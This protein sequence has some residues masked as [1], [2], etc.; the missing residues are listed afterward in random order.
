LSEKGERPFHK[1]LTN[2]KKKKKKVP[3]KFLTNGPDLLSKKK[4]ESEKKRSEKKNFSGMCRFFK[5]RG[6]KEQAWGL[7]QGGA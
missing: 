4:R 5:K 2:G 7:A 6:K 3:A 1:F